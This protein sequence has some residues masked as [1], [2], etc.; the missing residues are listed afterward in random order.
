MFVI[1]PLNV[2]KQTTKSMSANLP[3][4]PY[5]NVIILRNQKIKDL[6]CLRIL[7]L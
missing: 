2:K 4:T 6:Y 7:L 1:N 5:P 3:K